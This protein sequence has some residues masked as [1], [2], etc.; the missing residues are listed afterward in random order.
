[1]KQIRKNTRL[2]YMCNA[3]LR[4]N[5]GFNV[6][7]EIWDLGIWVFFLLLQR[8]SESSLG[9]NKVWLTQRKDFQFFDEG[10]GE[11]N[12]R[13]IHL[14]SWTEG[15]ALVC[16]QIRAARWLSWSIG[17]LVSSPA[18]LPRPKTR[19]PEEVQYNTVQR[20]ETNITLI[21]YHLVPDRNFN[22]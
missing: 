13:S 21:Q 4:K 20:K 12:N 17:L 9:I 1:M 16:N 18:G 10:G 15:L 3:G 5:T 7:W 22:K 2:K 14:S 11:K 19:T 6:S 8:M